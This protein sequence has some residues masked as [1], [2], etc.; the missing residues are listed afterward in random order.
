MSVAT[1][2]PLLH[3]AN[4]SGIVDTEGVGPTDVLLA[5]VV[6]A[7]TVIVAVA[8]SW[9]IRRWLDRPESG[10]QEIAALAARLARWAIVIIGASWALSFVGVS[11]GWLGL[12]VVAMLVVVVMV[13]RPQLEGL[14]AAVVVTT[15]P[16]FGVGDEIEV[17]AHKGEVLEV[18]ARSVVLRLRNGQRVHVPNNTL[19]S[20]V[21]TVISTDRPRRTEI[22]FEVEEHQDIDRLERLSLAAIAGL[23]NVADEPAPVLRARDLGSGAVTVAIRFWHDSRISSEI[24]ATDEAVRA[25]RRLY[26]AEGITTDTERLSV[27]LRSARERQA[28]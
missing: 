3:L 28:S 17:L 5:V 7:L 18:T 21:V 27:T 23:A 1:P 25:L 8:V 19:L 24:Q 20:E 2:L 13:L 9:A 11:L 12:T 26:A 16:A 4:V 6:G 14:A 10:S 22:T 15:R